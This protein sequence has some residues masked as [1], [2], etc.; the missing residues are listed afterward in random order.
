MHGRWFRTILGL[1]VVLMLGWLGWRYSE[2]RRPLAEMVLS[3]GRS[4]RI[5]TGQIGDQHLDP[6]MPLHQRLMIWCPPGI[7]RILPFRST[8]G[9]V[10]VSSNS[11]SLWLVFEGKTTAPF[12]KEFQMLLGDGVSFAGNKG[13]YQSNT[14]SRGEGYELHMFTTWPRHEPTWEVRIYTS[15]SAY[16]RKLLGTAKVQNPLRVKSP[17]LQAAPPY[18]VRV[19][20]DDMELL[21][22]GIVVGKPADYRSMDDALDPADL[23]TRLEFDILKDGE[24]TTNWVSYHVVSMTD[25]FGNRSDGNSWNHGWKDDVSFI[26]FAEWPLPLHGAWNVKVEFIRI[27]GFPEEHVWNFK[28]VPISEVRL[29]DDLSNMSVEQLGRRLSIVRAHQNRG[30]SMEVAVSINPPLSGERITFLD[31]T[32]D[33][34]TQVTSGGW[35]GSADRVTFHLNG[36]DGAKELDMRLAIH[37]SVFAEFTAQPTAWKA[38]VTAEK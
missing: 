18:P 20:Q 3:D 16:P 33:K 13:H 31:G 35:S 34:G 21:L 8:Q 14:N 22:K 30:G 12:N 5:L 23:R 29:Q 7:R 27:G 15:E 6:Y 10:S 1:G 38:P 24:R 2:G 25:G 28:D 9:P 11:L 32:S 26:E 4:V 19:V 36:A 37:P 17:S